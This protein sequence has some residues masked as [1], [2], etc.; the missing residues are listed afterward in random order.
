MNIMKKPSTKYPKIDPKCS[1]VF[2]GRIGFD[3][4]KNINREYTFPML[5]H[6]MLEEMPY[7]QYFNRIVDILNGHEQICV[8]VGNCEPMH[9]PD[10]TELTRDKTLILVSNVT[11]ND[12]YPR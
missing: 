12:S 5:F 9:L 4:N 11:H 10:N 1:N 6:T 8:F 7:A 3:I 2:S